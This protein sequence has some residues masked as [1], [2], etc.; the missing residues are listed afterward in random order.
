MDPPEIIINLL[1]AYILY[2]VFMNNNY[3]ENHIR[4]A[5][6]LLVILVVYFRGLR[7]RWDIF[8]AKGERTV[9]MR[10]LK[11]YL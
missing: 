7:T 8:D 9:L 6:G 4:I 11:D 10:P 2:S 5:M 1:F 3:N